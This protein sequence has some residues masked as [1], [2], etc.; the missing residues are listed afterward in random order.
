MPSLSF[1]PFGENLESKNLVT[2]IPT[3][4]LYFPLIFVVFGLPNQWSLLTPFSFSCPV[5]LTQA[6][7]ASLE[8]NESTQSLARKNSSL[9]EDKPLHQRKSD[10]ELNRG[11]V[12]LICQSHSRSTFK[13]PKTSQ[14]PF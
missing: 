13:K 14:T 12:Y 2:S 6:I 4:S 9:M 5:Y 1:L 7:N 10:R 11:E 8:G 3:M